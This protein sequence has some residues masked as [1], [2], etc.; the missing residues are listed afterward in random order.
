[1]VTMV[2]I[3]GGEPGSSRR[4]CGSIL[5]VEWKLQEQTAAAP[6]VQQA[7]VAH[8]RA[9]SMVTAC[10]S[11]SPISSGQRGRCHAVD[12]LATS[13]MEVLTMIMPR[14]LGPGQ[15]LMGMPRRV[16]QHPPSPPTAT[17][18]CRSNVGHVPVVLPLT[19]PPP[20][21]QH[22]STSSGQ[23]NRRS[24]ADGSSFFSHSSG[25]I[26]AA[27]SSS[28]L[29]RHACTSAS[30]A[31]PGSSGG[32]GAP[33]A[34]TTPARRRRAPSLHVHAPGKRTGSAIMGAP[35]PGRRVHLHTNLA[36][37]HHRR[38]ASAHCHASAPHPRPRSCRRL[39]RVSC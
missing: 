20:A 11:R 8:H 30:S 29:L 18:S 27:W 37:R 38:V 13:I 24:S 28:H 26:S 9:S 33:A 31:S 3:A 25:S 39:E 2:K 19:C 21:T 36:T 17:L 23:Q 32:L 15:D 22:R 4:R 10:A 6:V 7:R 12:H 5:E 1:M 14:P 16:L 34:A 35:P